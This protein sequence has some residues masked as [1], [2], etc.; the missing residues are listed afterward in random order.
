MQ[1][2][3]VFPSHSPLFKFKKKYIYISVEC[4]P[5]K[6][7]SNLGNNDMAMI[8]NKNL[9]ILGFVCQNSNGHE[10]KPSYLSVRVAVCRVPCAD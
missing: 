5:Y 7:P 4:C 3:M 10:A 8:Y 6:L 1:Y 9:K 2:G